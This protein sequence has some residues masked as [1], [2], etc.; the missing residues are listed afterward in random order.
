MLDIPLATALLDSLKDSLLFA[1]TNHVI[2]YM[3][4][5][6]IAHYKEG[7]ALLGRSV[8]DCH[9]KEESRQRIRDA[10]AALQQGADE[11]LVSDGQK[12]RTFMRAVRDENGRLLG[13]YE[14]KE[15]KTGGTAATY[16]AIRP[17]A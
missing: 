4:Q 16:P 8:L 11:Q 14:R 5:A 2:R 6:A 1:D 13:Y 12:Q 9:Q 15:P 10:G 17:L 7:A 3:N